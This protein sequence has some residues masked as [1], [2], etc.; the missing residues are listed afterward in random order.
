MTAYV[1]IDFTK[2]CSISYWNIPDTISKYQKCKDIMEKNNLRDELNKIKLLIQDNECDMFTQTP[3]QNLG[4]ACLDITIAINSDNFKT[5]ES[6]G[7]FLSG[8][9]LKIVSLLKKSKNYL[10]N[11]Y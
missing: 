2:P 1:E 8:K 6:A 11:K 3:M 5:L 10:Q 9:L 7:N 4:I